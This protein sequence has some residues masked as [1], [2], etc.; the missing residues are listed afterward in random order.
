MNNLGICHNWESKQQPFGEWN[1]QLSHTCQNGNI[2][3]GKYKVA[4]LRL[5]YL[6]TDSMILAS[7]VPNSPIPNRWSSKSDPEILL[8]RYNSI[9]VF[10]H[11]VCPLP[12]WILAFLIEIMEKFI[13]LSQDVDKI[14][15]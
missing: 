8:Y 10:W 3:K 9:K 5:C 6:G 13:F 12:H 11:T 4:V 2:F 15:I 1:N 7:I 14:L